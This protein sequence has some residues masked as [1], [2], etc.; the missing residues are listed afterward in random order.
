MGDQTES[1]TGQGKDGSSY[2]SINRRRGIADAS[3]Y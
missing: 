3:R 2:R 1:A